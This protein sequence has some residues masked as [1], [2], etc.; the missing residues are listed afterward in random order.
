MFIV[1]DQ[2]FTGFSEMSLNMIYII[3]I[4]LG[5]LVI[6]SKN[7]I[8]SVLFLRRL[9]TSLYSLIFHRFIRF[10]V[11]TYVDLWNKWFSNFLFIFITIEALFMILTNIII[12]SP[13]NN[14]IW[15]L[16]FN[17][18]FCFLLIL[19][20]NTVISVYIYKLFEN[21]FYKF[22]FI[23]TIVII[24]NPIVLDYSIVFMGS[25]SLLQMET[26]RANFYNEYLRYSL[27]CIVLRKRI[28]TLN[29]MSS[30]F[31]SLT[32]P[33]DYTSVSSNIRETSRSLS[34]KYE[35][36]ITNKE[37]YFHHTNLIGDYMFKKESGSRL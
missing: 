32:L 23:T 31:D 18:I 19:I 37:F 20:I 15:S 35:I 1:Y 22:C 13:L 26:L 33:H 12:R 30:T 25:L 28:H 10:F 3:A 14:Y 11:N 16:S 2:T 9:Y 24:L 8:I 34:D 36:A 29:T 21:L 6:I 5:T 27:D 17:Y 4:L 7:P